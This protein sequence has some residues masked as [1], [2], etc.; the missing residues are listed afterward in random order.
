ME[1]KIRVFISYSHKN[2][3]VVIKLA[4]IIQEVGM[5]PLWAR[6]LPVGT[7]FDEQI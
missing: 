5:V 6:N 2:E 1:G 4:R 7:G 3:E